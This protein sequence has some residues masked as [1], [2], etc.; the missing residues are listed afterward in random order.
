VLTGGHNRISYA[1]GSAN[2]YKPKNIF[3]SGVYEKTT[4]K[5]IMQNRSTNGARVI[6]GR[7]AQNTQ[8]NA[9]EINDWIKQNNISEIL[10]ITSDYHLP[11]SIAELRHVNSDLK[12]FPCA[13]KSEFNL[14]F[15]GRCLKEF[16][17]VTYVYIRNFL[18][19]IIGRF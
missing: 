10:L 8:E 12:I 17:K 19:K 18:S 3:I 15:I 4:F 1:I 6:L 14:R 9:T 2:V 13:V 7:K 5:D 11:R 16:H